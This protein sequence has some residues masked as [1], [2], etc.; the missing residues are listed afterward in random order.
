MGLVTDAIDQQ[1]WRSCGPMAIGHTAYSTTG[2]CSDQRA[3]PDRPLLISQVAICHNGN[4]VN[5]AGSATAQHGHIFIA[6]SD[7]EVIL[8]A[9]RP[10]FAS[11]PDPL[12]VLRHLTGSYC[13]L[14]AYPDRIE[15]VRDPSGNR[16]CAWAARARPGWSAKPAP[17]T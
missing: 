11:Q 14:L 8:H 4:L 5:A 6:T 1:S 16:R 12:A 2:S 13:L 7:T 17:R 9:G 10:R 3:A 15:A